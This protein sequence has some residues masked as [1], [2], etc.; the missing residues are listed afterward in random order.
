MANPL[1]PKIIKLLKANGY[2]VINNHA[3]AIGMRGVPDLL[4]ISPEGKMTFIEIK[5]GKDRLSEL[6][7]YFIEELKKRNVSVIIA[8]DVSDISELIN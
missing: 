3:T 4:V 6:Q 7:K 8:R 2:L 5:Y 1:Q